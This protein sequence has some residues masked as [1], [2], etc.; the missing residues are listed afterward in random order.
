MVEIGKFGK[1]ILDICQVARMQFWTLEL[2][3]KKSLKGPL[4][5]ST[6]YNITA[7]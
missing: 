5:I 1:F 4:Y 3:M 7:I 2:D 6:L